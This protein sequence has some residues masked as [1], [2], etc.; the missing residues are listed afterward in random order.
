MHFGHPEWDRYSLTNRGDGTKGYAF[1]VGAKLD[2]GRVPANLA[3]VVPNTYDSAAAYLNQVQ[4]PATSY[5]PFVGWYKTTSRPYGTTVQTVLSVNGSCTFTPP[6]V[7]QAPGVFIPLPGDHF[8]HRTYWTGA[9][10]K[11]GEGSILND[12][13]HGT[14]LYSAN[15][16]AGALPVGAGP[17]WTASVG[18][19]GP[20][21][22][23]YIGDGDTVNT[24]MTKNLG[25][26]GSAISSSPS[27]GAGPNDAYEFPDLSLPF[28]C[29]TNIR[30]TDVV[31]NGPCFTK[32]Y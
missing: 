14:Y 11:S 1:V 6:P 7:R 9:A 23:A 24:M 20:S 5:G 19:G 12:H 10:F 29:A 3:S 2:G 30:C 4:T 32:F 28:L 22:R 16:I 27:G 15:A 13:T 8:G 17:P 25:T 18:G 31:L 21:T 26:S